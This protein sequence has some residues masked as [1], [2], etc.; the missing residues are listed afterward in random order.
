M[1]QRE[2][3][4]KTGRPLT[5]D[6]PLDVKRCVCFPK[7]LVERIEKMGGRWGFGRTVRRLVRKGLGDKRIDD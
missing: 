5:G 4:P 7:S 2:E 6:E 1:K 3:Q